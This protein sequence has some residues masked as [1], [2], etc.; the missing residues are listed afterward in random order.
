[1]RNITIEQIQDL[2]NNQEFMSKLQKTNSINEGILLMRENDITL[3][4][5]EVEAGYKKG[6]A[7]LEELGYL[8]NGE[9]TLDQVAGG[10]K[11]GYGVAKLGA[12]A[13]GVGIGLLLGGVCLTPAAGLIIIGGMVALGCCNL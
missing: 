7:Y 9:L 11:L 10:S 2:M 8:E 12:S 6:I 5:E 4:A 13:A 1:M 3:T